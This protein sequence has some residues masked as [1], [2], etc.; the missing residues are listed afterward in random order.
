MSA[1][2]SQPPYTAR[3]RTQDGLELLPVLC[4]I[5]DEYVLIVLVYRPPGTV[6]MFLQVLISQLSR[7]PIDKYR[8]L[9][10]GDFNLDQM[11]QE[12]VQLL[13]PLI[14]RFG[15]F[16]RTQ[17]STHVQGGILD[18]VMDNRRTDHIEWIPSPYSDHFII[19]ISV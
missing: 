16:Q 5:Q 4:K 7:L 12:N 18:L 17:F 13:T 15:L 9:I 6:G 11:L 14:S 10:I 2:I 8:T 1:T 3:V 19:L